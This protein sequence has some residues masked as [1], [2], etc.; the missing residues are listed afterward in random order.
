MKE[1]IEGP[2]GW[3][4][5]SPRGRGIGSEEDGIGGG[6]DAVVRGV[7]C[8]VFCNPNAGMYECVNMSPKSADWVCLYRSKGFQVKERKNQ[9]PRDYGDCEDTHL[10]PRP[11]GSSFVFRFPF[12]VP[13]PPPPTYPTCR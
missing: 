8:A 11:C 4:R 10:L 6:R 5:P 13:P 2:R 1:G 12:L 7:P 3:V 9:R